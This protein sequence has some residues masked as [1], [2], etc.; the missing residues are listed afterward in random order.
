MNQV[1]RFIKLYIYLIITFYR[2]FNLSESKCD[3]TSLQNA[4]DQVDVIVNQSLN[5]IDI[6]DNSKTNLRK[7][8]DCHGNRYSRSDL[9]TQYEQ[10]CERKVVIQSVVND[11]L[12]K[13]K[14]LEKEKERW[15]KRSKFYYFTKQF[16]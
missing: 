7:S 16:Q 9:F 12:I 5:W 3:E 2:L 11:L 14:I 8:I 15:A 1:F 6:I 4:I 13:K 10:L